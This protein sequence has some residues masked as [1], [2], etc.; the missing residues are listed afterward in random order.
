MQLGFVDKLL[1]PER[2][3]LT[4]A[5]GK[6][7]RLFGRGQGTRSGFGEGRT[8]G[9]HSSGRATQLLQCQRFH[10][11]QSGILRVQKNGS[12]RF[13]H[14][15]ARYLPPHCPGVPRLRDFANNCAAFTKCRRAC[16]RDAPGA[17]ILPATVLPS[18]LTAHNRPNPSRTI[19][20]VTRIS[21]KNKNLSRLLALSSPH[22]SF[23]SFLF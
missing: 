12:I 5:L 2:K 10:D 19:A 1:T 23:G 6:R 13:S 11:V 20:K 3:K 21:I 22:Q 15:L 14:G 4:C 17:R 9:A 7:F 18:I 16:D 8:Q